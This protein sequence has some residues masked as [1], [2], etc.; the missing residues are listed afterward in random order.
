MHWQALEQEKHS[1]SLK[2]EA[3]VRME[4]SL[5][6]EVEQLRE[7]QTLQIAGLAAQAAQSH[8]EE[9]QRHTRKVMADIRTCD[10]WPATLIARILPLC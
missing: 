6:Q 9:L 4:H 8:D 3:S 2:L 5:V 10:G 7:H 1:L